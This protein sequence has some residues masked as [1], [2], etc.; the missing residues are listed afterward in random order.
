[1]TERFY[2]FCGVNQNDKDVLGLLKDP[3][4]RSMELRVTGT[5]QDSLPTD[6]EMHEIQKVCPCLVFPMAIKRGLGGP[7][8][9][10]DLKAHMEG[11]MASVIYVDHG[12][13]LCWAANEIK[14]KGEK[15]VE[16]HVNG[17]ELSLVKYFINEAVASD[18]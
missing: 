18:L 12:V 17:T 13:K 6:K 5:S 3:E 4:G 1:M 14:M 16:I 9:S 7:K 10:I 8:E 2:I 15:A 11:K